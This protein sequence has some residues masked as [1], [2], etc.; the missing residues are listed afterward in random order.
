MKTLL[1]EMCGA[2]ISAPNYN[3]HMLSCCGVGTWKQKE[4]LRKEKY[5]LL[6]ERGFECVVCHKK[7]TSIQGLNGHAARTHTNI[8]K[9]KEYG[10]IG[11]A[12]QEELTA[13]GWRRRVVQHTAETKEKLSLMMIEKL[14]RKPFWSKRSQYKGITLDSSYEL[15]VAKS[16][17]ENGIEWMRPS[18]ALRY[19]DGKQYRHYLPDF[20]LPKYDVY[21]DPKNDFLIEKHKIKIMLAE[22]Q[23]N[24][25]VV[26]LSKHELDWNTIQNKLG[27]V[28]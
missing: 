16:L 18:S 7:F 8:H 13:Q 11:R 21:L 20:Y 6:C 3:R 5:K 26:V 25:K 4:Q 23:N 2:S 1:C 9:Q 27:R 24:T 28:V 22:E 14:S 12:R 19:F 17:D 10:R 15:A